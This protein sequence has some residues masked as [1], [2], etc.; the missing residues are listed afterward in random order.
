MKPLFSYC[1]AILLAGLVSC[2]ESARKEPVDYVNP[3]TGTIGHLLVATNSMT[4]LDVYKRQ[5]KDTANS[6]CSNGAA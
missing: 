6:S 1:L 5:V 3:N 4:Q 2:V